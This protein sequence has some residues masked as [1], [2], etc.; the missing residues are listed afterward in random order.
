MLARR[1]ER[2]LPGIVVR[3]PVAKLDVLHFEIEKL[4]N[5][6]TVRSEPRPR[7]VRGSI[8]CD[9]DSQARAFEY[10]GRNVHFLL[11]QRD[12]SQSD[13]D[14]VRTQ[15]GRSGGGL[16]AMQDERRNLRRQI[17]PVIGETADFDTAAG[18]AFGHRHDLFSNL[19]FEPLRLRQHNAR[20][21]HR[22][23]EARGAEEAGCDDFGAPGHSLPASRPARV[24]SW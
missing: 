1:V 4:F 15:Q 3:L 16:R 24:A 5:E 17:A 22:D 7:N 18:G 21:Q 19:V 2:N 9:G 13:F 6:I 14:L 11:E 20:G 23:Y 10:E 8:R 12:D